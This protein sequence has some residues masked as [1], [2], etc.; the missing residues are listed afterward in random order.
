MFLPNSFSN[1]CD[2][3]ESLLFC[4]KQALR[5]GPLRIH[6][7]R[8]A[9]EAGALAHVRRLVAAIFVRTFRPDRFVLV[10]AN[11]K[12]SAAY[13]NDLASSGN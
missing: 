1:G 8:V 13:V 2:V 6:P 3:R 11:S 5:E 12:F 10:E 9:T 7:L 4:E